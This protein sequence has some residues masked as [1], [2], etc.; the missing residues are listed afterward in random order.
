MNY[1]NLLIDY[2][3]AIRKTESEIEGIMPLAVGEALNNVQDNRVVF[4]DKRAKVVLTTRKLFPTVKDCVILERLEADILATTAQLAQS[5]QNTLARID[6]EISHLK[7]AIAELEAEKEILLTNRRLI[8][9]KHQFKAEREGR[10]EL[11]PILNVQL[12]A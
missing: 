4:A 2:R 9:L 6:A 8:Q 1:L 3:I 12:F 5:K 11:K 10:V 7:Q